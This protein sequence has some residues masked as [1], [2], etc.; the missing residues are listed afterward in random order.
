MAG[1]NFEISQ[2]FP[3]KSKFD[4]VNLTQ[5]LLKA[6]KLGGVKKFIYFS[7][8]HVYDGNEELR[9]NEKTPP[10]PIDNYSKFHLAAEK[11]IL[12]FSEDYDFKIHILRLTNVIGYPTSKD[13]NCWHLVSN[14][15]FKQ[16][17]TESQIIINSS[18]LTKI[19]FIPISG[20][21]KLIVYL[22][23][24]NVKNNIIN[25]NSGKKISILKLAKIIKKKIELK[26]N[27]KIKLV[28]SMERS[29]KKNII[30]KKIYSNKSIKDLLNYDAEL[31]FEIDNSIKKIIRWFY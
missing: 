13:T 2:K 5:S 3:K 24:N 11:E 9:I 12:K 23:K 15:F 22:L 28:Y 14:D 8:I 6:A 4:R 21:C 27:K 30:S 29:D 26:L 19:D 1:P 20:L 18:P 25:V 7:T 31:E 10:K 17:V 16:A